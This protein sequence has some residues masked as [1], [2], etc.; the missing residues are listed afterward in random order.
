MDKPNRRQGR[1]ARR[2]SPCPNAAEHRNNHNPAAAPGRSPEPK[3][4]ST[5]NSGS[6]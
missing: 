2:D 6:L 1:K 3:A 4:S 5:T